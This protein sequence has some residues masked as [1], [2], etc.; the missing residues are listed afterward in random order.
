MEQ[1]SNIERSLI[2]SAK[3]RQLQEV[4]APRSFYQPSKFLMLAYAISLRRYTKLDNARRDYLL[5]CIR[6]ENIS[7]VITHYGLSEF[8]LSDI[9]EEL[10]KNGSCWW[11]NGHHPALSSIAYAEPLIYVIESRN[12]GID[13]KEISTN[14]NDYWGEKISQ[15]ELLKKIQ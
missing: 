11:I 8:D 2:K 3:I 7:K 15:G 1:I 5:L 9:C 12:R 13:W 14:I 4:I 10:N 6:D